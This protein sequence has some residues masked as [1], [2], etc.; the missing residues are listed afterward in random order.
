[1]KN[2]S[3]IPDSTVKKIAKSMGINNSCK[4]LICVEESLDK[5]GD[6]RFSDLYNTAVIYLKKS[7][8]TSTLVHELRHLWQL[9]TLGYETF[10]TINQM[11]ESLE[12][13]EKNIFEIDAFAFEAEFMKN[14][15]VLC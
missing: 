7:D 1:M 13:Y 10:D 8:D 14:M 3:D 11:E 5:A 9:Q 12:G 2:L 4:V 15:D 6:F